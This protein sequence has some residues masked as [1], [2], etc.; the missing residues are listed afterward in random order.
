MESLPAV[1][2]II[3]T[4]NRKDSLLRTLDSLSCQTYPMD[5]FEVIVVDD[6]STDGTQAVTEK[7]Y[8]YTLRYCYQ[9]NQGE[10]MARNFGASKS[11]AQG[12]VFLDDD[13][14]V[15]QEYLAN[16]AQEH[17]NYE[18]TIVLA[19]IRNTSLDSN[20]PFASLYDRVIPTGDITPDDGFVSLL[21]CLSGILSVKRDD[22]FTIGMMQLLPGGGKRN[23]W[24]GLDFGYRA[25]RLGFR[26]RRCSGA[27]AYHADHGIYDLA[28]YCQNRESVS[29]V[30]SLLLQKYPGLEQGIP[31]F[32]D[33]GPISLSS[34]PPRLII[35]KLLRM[36]M[37]NPLSVWVM[38]YLVRILEVKAPQSLPL[39]LLYRWIVSAYI[40][41][42]Y[43]RDLRE[44]AEAKA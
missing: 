21:E 8:P 44:L 15:N 24:G 30:A 7:T 4:Y 33:K 1:N 17:E 25:F 23:R 34:D 29:K 42:G 41:K 11:A 31:M 10:H 12:L 37:S 3:P 6:G 19:T 43:R 22:F 38:A 2:V 9:H 35:R 27:I 32:R 28:S 39:V 18:R 5:Y 14:T 13:I 40:Y 20:T 26:F 16:L 36:G